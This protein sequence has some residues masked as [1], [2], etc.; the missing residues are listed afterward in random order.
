MTISP[1]NLAAARD[2][3]AGI[4]TVDPRI[5]SIR[6]LMPDIKAKIDAGASMKQVCAALAPIFGGDEKWVSRTIV[7]LRRRRGGKPRNSTKAKQGRA[8]AAP[9]EQP[10]R[11]LR[12]SPK[13][14]ATP[15]NAAAE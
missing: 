9:V 4:E 2:A 14:A 15:A 3:L 11:T 1:L 10:R 13:P 7:Q 5:T 12:L 6:E 8:D